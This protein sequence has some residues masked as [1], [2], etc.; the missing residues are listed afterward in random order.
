MKA[1][2]RLSQASGL[3][4]ACLVLSGIKL[5]GNPV[6]GGAFGDVYRGYL[7]DQILAIKILKVYEMSERDELLKVT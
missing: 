6:A 5:Q 1:L 4:P 2:I 3:Y 7:K